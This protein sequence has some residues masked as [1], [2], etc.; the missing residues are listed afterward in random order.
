MKRKTIQSVQ[1]RINLNLIFY[2]FM[3][4]VDIIYKGKMDLN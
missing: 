2:C 4:V 3:Y 1:N